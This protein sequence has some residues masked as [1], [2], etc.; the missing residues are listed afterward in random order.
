[1]FCLLL[2]PHAVHHNHTLN[3]L[4]KTIVFHLVEIAIH[5]HRNMDAATPLL[6]RPCFCFT[7]ASL[8]YITGLSV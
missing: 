4:F 6:V 3:L 8:T 1:M 7:Y 2:Q 5:S